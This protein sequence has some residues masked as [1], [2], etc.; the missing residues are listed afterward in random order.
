MLEFIIEYAVIIISALG[1][2]G[3]LILMILESMVFPI[4]SEA[5]M[6]FAGFLCASGSMN[7][8]IATLFAT[9]GS[10]IGSWFSYWIGQ[11][12]GRPFVL[13][14]GK[15]V[16]I[17]E[18][19]LDWTQKWFN[20]YGSVTIFVGRFIPVVRHLISIPAGIGKMNPIKFTVFTAAGAFLWNLFL[21][22][23][24][25]ILGEHWDTIK[26]YTMPLDII[27][28]V[29]ILIGCVYF[30]MHIKKINQS[31]KK[32]AKRLKKHKN[33]VLKK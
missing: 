26:K 31:N 25:V 20:K 27:I 4:P 6:P 33:T 22:Y 17:D 32:K 23:I 16:G 15:Y 14:F 28:I 10:I 29:C 9:L 1:Y 3:I 2:P 5:V 18:N 21:T 11:F 24:G 19:H 13:K 30:F 12:G 7:I 8:W